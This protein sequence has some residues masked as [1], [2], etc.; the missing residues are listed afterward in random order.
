MGGRILTG[1]ALLRCNIFSRQIVSA[2][3][4]LYSQKLLSWHSSWESALLPVTP[5]FSSFISSRCEGQ[6]MLSV[7]TEFNMEQMTYHGLMSAK[8]QIQQSQT[9][10]LRAEPRCISC[11][12]CRASFNSLIYCITESIALKQPSPSEASS[13]CEQQRIPPHGKYTAG[14]SSPLDS[15]V[16][17]LAP[18]QHPPVPLDPFL[19]YVPGVPRHTEPVPLSGTVPLQPGGK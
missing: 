4:Y 12:S 9:L 17:L 16:R 7:L 11:H 10:L 2:Q 13:G 5:G 18:E 3:N 15:T 19:L 6:S 14:C 1:S 8:I